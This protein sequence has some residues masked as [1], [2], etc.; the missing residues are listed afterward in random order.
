MDRD[1]L[2][3]VVKRILKR[4]SNYGNPEMCWEW[5][6]KKSQPRTRVRRGFAL[7]QPPTLRV[8]KDR[9]YAS[10]QHNK[11]YLNPVRVVY[12]YLKPE[13][14]EIERPW[15]LLN[16]CGN[17]LCCNPDHWEL[18]IPGQPKPEKKKAGELVSTEPPSPEETMALDCQDL[19]DQIFSMG[20]PATLEDLLGH[21][22]MVDFPREL[23]IKC[24]NAMG[25]GHI[26][27]AN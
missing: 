5:T 18:L 19:L 21:A 2:A 8:Q 11:K 12:E 17:S 23:I 15:K 6:G 14:S 22:Y 25:K 1:E 26:I 9:P 27:N 16:T 24:L 20:G 7:G 13:T 3:K 4:I 10:I